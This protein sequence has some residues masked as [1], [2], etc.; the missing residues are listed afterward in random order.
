MNVLYFIASIIYDVSQ[1]RFAPGISGKFNAVENRETS[2]ITSELNSSQ[3]SYIRLKVWGT[4][5]FI[6]MTS[7]TL[8]QT[9]ITMS[10]S[11][12]PQSNHATSSFST[13]QL[14]YYNSLSSRLLPP[15][16]S[17]NLCE[18]WCLLEGE[19]KPFAVITDV[20]QNLFQLQQLIQSQKPETSSSQCRCFG[21]RPVE[22]EHVLIANVY[23]PLML[24][25]SSILWRSNP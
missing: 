13:L 25:S 22:S 8:V 14:L 23:I 4:R 9:L 11:R 5:F 3:P 19:A 15:M 24:Y 18:L 21:Y 17:T 7:G 16:Q 12:D 1:S 20:G 10:D 2:L 6:Y